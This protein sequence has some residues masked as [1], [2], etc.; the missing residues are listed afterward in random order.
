MAQ[1][2]EFLSQQAAAAPAAVPAPILPQ[3]PF[4]PSP[5]GDQGEWE[6]TPQPAQEDTL[7]IA[8]SWDRASFSD[9]EVGGEL[10]PLAEAGPSLKV[11]SKASAPPLSDLTSALMGRTAA[12]LQ[13]PWT[14]AA[15][16]HRSVFRT[17][18]MAPRA[19]KFPSFLDFMEE[20]RFSWDRPASAPSVLKQA[21]QL[22]SLEG[23]DKPGLAGF[24]PV[25][26]TIAA[27]VKALPVGGLSKEP[28]CLN[29]QCRVTEMHLK[30]AYTA[31]A[32]VTR[33]A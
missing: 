32:Q 3:V 23:A 14:L 21:T 25:D 6:E 31:E 17:Q 22:A 15:E 30:R 2:L 29:P 16:P 28:A 9:M 5:R 19:Q 11:Y 26:S 33:F 18:T 8:P 12:F 1:V 27:L 4:P 7:S 24:P 13:V 10:V 20:V